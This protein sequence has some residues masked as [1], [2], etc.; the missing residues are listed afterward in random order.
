MEV[1]KMSQYSESMAPDW[2]VAVSP[3]AARCPAGGGDALDARW[4][5]WCDV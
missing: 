4:D 1:C 5:R 2:S 3:D